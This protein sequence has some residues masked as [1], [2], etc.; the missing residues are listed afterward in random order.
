MNGEKLYHYTSV[1]GFESII[2][3]KCIRMT[4]SDFM[5]DP[6]DC[7]VFFDIV[8]KYINEKM[9]TINLSEYLHHKDNHRYVEE[10][11]RRYP[12]VAYMKYLFKTIPLYVL[13]LT[14]E[15][16][17][18]PMWNYYGGDGIRLA[19]DSDG[20]IHTMSSSLCR[21]ASDFLVK[22]RVEYIDS[23]TKLEDLTLNSFSDF[24]V[25]SYNGK[26]ERAELR[27]PVVQHNEGEN[28]RY[29]ID[30]FIVSYIKTIAYMAY[31]EDIEGI[32][33]CRRMMECPSKDFFICVFENNK[34]Q[35]SEKTRFKADIDL[36]MLILAA[37]YKTK[38]FE[39][40]NETRIVFFKQDELEKPEEK[41]ITSEYKFGSFLKPLIECPFHTD[42][43]ADIL[44]AP[45]A[46]QLPVHMETYQKL[47]REF[48]GKTDDFIVDVS[49]HD[50][51]W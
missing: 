15:A 18:L 37:R 26:T 38:T 29:F 43:V 14:G 35:S 9:G 50:V 47:I 5:N 3:N 22:T 8:E 31:S 6:H 16:D 36:Y 28:L 21:D 13:S 32:P 2:K 7:Q 51:R 4:R 46:K 24:Y 33:N 17:S 23:D 11:L 39:N 42:D 10:V 40:E 20:L 41:I 34:G 12:P 1:R 25:Y 49:K 48:C 19:F 27:T 45:S 44:L 30:S